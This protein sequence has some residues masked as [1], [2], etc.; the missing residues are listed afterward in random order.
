MFVG[1]APCLSLA[2]VH[3]LS[4]VFSEVLLHFRSF[5]GVDIP[6]YPYVMVKVFAEVA[7]CLFPTLVKPISAKVLCREKST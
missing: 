3:V 5:E 1:L 2:I 4:E 6:M 7:P